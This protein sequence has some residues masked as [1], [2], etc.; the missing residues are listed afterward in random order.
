MPADLTLGQD[1]RHA[2]DHGDAGGRASPARGNNF[3]LTTLRRP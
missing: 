3:E 2:D 1:D